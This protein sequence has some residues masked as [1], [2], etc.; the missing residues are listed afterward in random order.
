VKELAEKAKARPA[1][2]L[3]SQIVKPAPK[4]LEK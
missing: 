4:K 1:F 3:F 2:Q